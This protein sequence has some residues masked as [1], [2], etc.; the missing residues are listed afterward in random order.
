MELVEKLEPFTQKARRQKKA[1]N[2]LLIGR[3]TA[4]EKA[5]A[6]EMKRVADEEWRLAF[7][8]IL[9]LDKLAKEN[10]SE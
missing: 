6:A 4:G 9:L 2:K 8:A 7:G 3:P 10:S 1:A 5:R